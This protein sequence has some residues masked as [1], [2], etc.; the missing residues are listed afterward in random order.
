M[1]SKL[2]GLISLSLFFFS[3]IMA[4]TAFFLE[5]PFYGLGYAVLLPGCCLAIVFSYCAK[6]PVRLTSC[7]HV[8]VG[9]ITTL[10]P[11]RKQGPYTDLDYLIVLTSLLSLI[12]IPQF[13]LWEHTGLLIAFWVSLFI[14][15]TEIN[16]FV[17]PECDN[18]HCIAC[19]KN[20]RINQ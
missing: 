2:H 6:C 5:S 7:G 19:K 16:Q 13:W 20:K 12:L 1:D 18:T 10:L 14:A 17:C 8:I 9:K 11:P 15:G 4:L 3:Q